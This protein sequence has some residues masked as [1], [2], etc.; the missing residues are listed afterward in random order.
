MMR[1]LF[2]I[3]VCCGV[4]FG[5]T[6]QSFG[7]RAGLNYTKFS[8]PL[9]SGVNEKYSL[10]NGFHFGVNY[11]YKIADI[12]SIKGEALYTQIGSSYNYDGDSYYK[13][14]IGNAF[15]YEKG[16]ST[17]EMKVSNAYISIPVTFQWQASKKLE[18]YAGGY[19]SFLIGPRGN[20]TVYFEKDTVSLYFKQSLIHNYSKDQ[21]GGIATNTAGS[22]V[23]VDGKVVTLARDAGAY[24]NYLANEKDGNLYNSFDA[25]LTFGANYYINKGFYVGFKY[26]YG[27]LDVTNNK[28]DR[29][30]K[31]YD[32]A[33][34]KS[35]LA[36][37]F[38]R[39]V[40]FEV[41]FGFRF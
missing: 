5:M 3:V 28:M 8:G 16:K 41:S 27:L 23:Y 12:F 40:G 30:R 15:V 24:Y 9:E 35:L 26:N 21:A 36:S 22:S 34:N 10:S 6:A 1:H 11:A 29:I 13:V 37:D 19:A 38:D 7:I 4:A 25:G 33:N 31:T 18:F 39:N 17:I 2:L 14:P 32:E 20:G